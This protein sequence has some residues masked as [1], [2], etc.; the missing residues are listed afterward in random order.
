AVL[1]QT[2]PTAWPLAPSP[3][4]SSTVPSASTST[5]VVLGSVQLARAGCVSV[6]ASLN[7]SGFQAPSGVFLDRG[8]SRVARQ[9]QR[10]GEGRDEGAGEAEALHAP[11]RQCGDHECRHRS[12][13][14][15]EARAH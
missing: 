11:A 4:P 1:K 5:A 6:I 15:A 12:A 8:H 13:D 7:L 9:D 14:G 3:K 10:G 2:S